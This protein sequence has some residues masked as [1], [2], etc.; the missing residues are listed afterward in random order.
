MWKKRLAL[1]SEE[2]LA[3]FQVGKFAVLFE[4]VAIA[5]PGSIRPGTIVNGAGLTCWV[6]WAPG[7]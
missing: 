3:P 2:L 6:R 7:K 4:V 1:D 5:A